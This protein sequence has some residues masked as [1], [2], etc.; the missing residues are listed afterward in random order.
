ML[1]DLR[2]QIV[3]RLR[4]VGRTGAL[5]QRKIAEPR[6]AKR[7]VKR[8]C[9]D[10]NS[11]QSQDCRRTAQLD[12][13]CDRRLALT[14]RRGQQA[15]TDLDACSTCFRS[16]NQARGNIAI[17][18]SELILVDDR[19]IAVV[20]RPGGATQWP[21]HGEDR[22]GRHQREHKPQR[23]QAGSGETGALWRRADM[24][25]YTTGGKPGN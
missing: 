22:R 11:N 20:L 2:H 13:R 16:T 19:L 9:D 10:W 14:I 6:R 24:P 23:H 18:L 15:T 17:D 21:E 3:E 4:D 25:L 5:R 12:V 7:E 1:L 8:N